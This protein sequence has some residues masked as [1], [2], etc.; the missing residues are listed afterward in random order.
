MVAS[1]INKIKKF[2]YRS[3]IFIDP[4]INPEIIPEN[5]FYQKRAMDLLNQEETLF[6]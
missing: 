2:R 1:E 3:I 5:I 4:T 6:E